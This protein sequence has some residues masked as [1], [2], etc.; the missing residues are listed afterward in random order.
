MNS[1]KGAGSAG[2]ATILDNEKND[3][4]VGTIKFTADFFGL[5]KYLI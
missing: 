1:K 5:N 2:D 3:E 4:I